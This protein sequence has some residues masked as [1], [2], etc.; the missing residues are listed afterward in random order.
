[1]TQPDRSDAAV[2]DGE[3]NRMKGRIAQ[4][5]DGGGQQQAPMSLGR[6]GQQGRHY[7]TQQ[8]GLQH[9]ARTHPIHQEPRKGLTHA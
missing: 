7:K 8:R 3:V 4:T 2:Q 5:G 6:S 1:M 9:R